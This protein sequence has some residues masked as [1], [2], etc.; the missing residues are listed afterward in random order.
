MGESH[1]QADLLAI[2]G[3]YSRDGHQLS[4]DAVLTPEPD[5]PHDAGAVAVVIEG[6]KVGYLPADRAASYLQRLAAAGHPGAPILCAAKIVGGWKTNQH[7]AGHFGVRLA[8]PARGKL[9]LG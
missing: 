1:F 4:C 5:N 2:C 8:L 7:D 9:I 6:R 3:G